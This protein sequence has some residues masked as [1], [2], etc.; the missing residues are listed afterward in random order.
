[1]DADIRKGDTFNY[2]PTQKTKTTSGLFYRIVNPPFSWMDGGHQP[3]F[4]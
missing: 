4:Y 1:M 3:K 2:S